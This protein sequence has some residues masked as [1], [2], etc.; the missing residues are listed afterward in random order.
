MITEAMIKASAVGGITMLWCYFTLKTM[1]IC[2]QIIFPPKIIH[3]ERCEYCAKYFTID[4]LS[5]R[6]GIN[7][8]IYVCNRCAEKEVVCEERQERFL[9]DG[10]V[11]ENDKFLCRS[12]RSRTIEKIVSKYN[13]V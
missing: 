8:Y 13:H 2:R 3:T 9:D 10:E 12:C 6:E 1:K 4:L 7:C 11:L 5:E